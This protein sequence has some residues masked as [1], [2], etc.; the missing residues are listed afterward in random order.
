MTSDELISDARSWLGT[1]WRHQ[2]RTRTGIDCVGLVRQVAAGRG[3]T[4]F[5]TRDYAAQ[6]SDETMLALCREHL[7]EVSKRDMHPGCVVVMR[8]SNQRHMGFVG[9]YVHG[10]LSLI[11][12]TSMHPRKVVEVRFD[13]VWMSRVMAVFEIPGVV[14]PKLL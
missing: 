8:F 14:W 13:E 7:T 2:G 12:A 9:D 11:H 6:A 10:G 5:D 1:P 3:L 4:K